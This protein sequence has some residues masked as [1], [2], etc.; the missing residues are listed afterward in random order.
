MVVGALDGGSEALFA[1]D[2]AVLPENWRVHRGSWWRR[3]LDARGTWF[4]DSAGISGRGW[5]VS[6]LPLLSVRRVKVL[7]IVES[8]RVGGSVESANEGLRHAL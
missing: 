5:G 2:A 4:A 6:R 7:L 8:R 1:L 3:R